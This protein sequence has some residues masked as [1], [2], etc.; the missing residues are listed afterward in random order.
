M[1]TTYCN[2]LLWI[3]LTVS[4]FKRSLVLFL[5]YGFSIIILCYWVKFYKIIFRLKILFMHPIVVLFM[6][7]VL[8]FQFHLHLLSG[9]KMDLVKWIDG[10]GVYVDRG[11]RI[12]VWMFLGSESETQFLLQA[13]QRYVF[14]LYIS[15]LEEKNVSFKVVPSIV[16]TFSKYYICFGTFWNTHLRN[17][18]LVLWNFSNRLKYFGNGVGGHN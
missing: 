10:W 2:S 12:Q 4:I 18:A 3:C 11:W 16:D 15:I 9:W 8:V 13:L 17:S 7:P 5:M 14:S 6:F 1:P